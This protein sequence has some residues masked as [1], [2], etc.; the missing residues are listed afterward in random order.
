MK[1]RH[2]MHIAAALIAAISLCA[3]PSIAFATT[4]K[5]KLDQAEREK[6]QLEE[7]LEKNKNELDGLKQEHNTLKGELGVLNQDL[8][9]IST[10]LEELETQ[11]ENKEAEIEQTEIALNNAIKEAEEQYEA[12]KVRI[13][14]N[15][16]AGDTAFLELLLNAGSF[17]DMLNA[18]EYIE[19]VSDY[20]KEK[21]ESYKQVR[22]SIK[23]FQEQKIIEKAEL[24]ALK[25]QVEAEKSKVAGLVSKTRNNMSAYSS[26][27]SQT[28]E[29]ML[30]YEA[31]LKEK[32]KD[33]ETLKKKYEEEKRLSQLSANSVKRDIS[34]VTFAEGDRYLLASIIYCEAG[35]E[36]YEGKLAVG[37]V[38]INRVLS[39][40]FPDT[41]VGVVYANKQFSPVASGRLALAMAEGRATESCYK[42]ADEAM[43][44]VTNVGG[45]VYF[46]T[47][48]EGLTG[49]TI[50][51]HIFY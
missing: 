29:E 51:G 2:K 26:Q 47:P 14:L 50:G 5:D 3:V 36:S 22:D 15:Y 23:E 38:V 21:L 20:D 37:A 6:N 33:I 49:I 35:G 11:I 46:R 9:T 12:M 30:A 1:T 4:T 40:V 43:A 19:A 41:V 16:E 17:G 42:A 44:G 18:A 7:E 34:D 10:N 32:E 25:V 48:I 45:C 31:E 24:D 27:I 39:S 28:E 13:Q 8:T